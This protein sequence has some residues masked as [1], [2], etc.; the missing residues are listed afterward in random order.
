MP[1]F[2]VNFS[3]LCLFV[4]RPANAS[5]D[6]MFPTPKGGAHHASHFPVLHLPA[7]AWAGMSGSGPMH[8]R[9]G[10]GRP[11]H[12]YQYDKVE[13]FVD[14]ER[15]SDGVEVTELPSQPANPTTASDWSDFRHILSASDALP[16]AVFDEAK[17]RAVSVP[18]WTLNGGALSAAVPMTQIDDRPWTIA[19]NAGTEVRYLSDLVSYSVEFLNKVDLV[20]KHRS[21]TERR[22]TL[23]SGQDV[24][25]WVAH[26]PYDEAF[27]P[28][29]SKPLQHLEVLAQCFSGV[30]EIASVAPTPVLHSDCSCCKSMQVVV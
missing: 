11:L 2:T 1:I 15:P 25:A 17:A 3:G 29:T 9:R 26:D 14:D 7:S 21:G 16:G 23:A 13:L 20:L 6:V 30:S 24:T 27:D 10:A 4:R 12:L 22:V 8:P 18:R 5:V 28:I 19:T